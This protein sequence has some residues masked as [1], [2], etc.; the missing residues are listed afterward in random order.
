MTT[1]TPPLGDAIELMRR[2]WMLNHELERLSARMTRALGITAQQRMVLRIVGRFPG[3]TAGRLSE[4]LCVDAATV[5]TGLAKLEQR[6]L[7]T[8]EREAKD[9]RRVVVALTARGRELDIPTTGTVEAGVEA[10]LARG[11][12]EDVAATHRVLDALASA[13]GEQSAPPSDV[14]GRKPP[15]KR[16]AAR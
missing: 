15:R 8:R 10:M 16:V 1:P 5:S 4:L 7:L 12:A 14:P 11:A 3:V 6:G 9:R 2:L 13:F